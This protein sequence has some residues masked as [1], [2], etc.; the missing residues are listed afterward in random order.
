[1]KLAC[2]Y[3]NETE[4]LARESKIDIDYFKFPALGF[5]MDVLQEQN[6]NLFRDFISRVTPLKPVL[7]HGLYP[8]RHDVSSETFIH[9]FDKEKV[10]LFLEASRTPGISLHPCLGKPDSAISEKQLINTIVKNIGFLQSAYPRMDFIAI[11]NPDAPWF[12]PLL[13]PALLSEI[14]KQAGCSFLL[15]ISHAFCGAYYTGEDFKEY[16]YKLPLAQVSEVHINGWVQKGEDLIM[17]HTKINEAGYKILEEL[18]NRCAPKIITIEYGRHND[19]IGAGCPVVAP[20]SMNKNAMDEIV[21]QVERMK[22]I[23][24]GAGR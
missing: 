19:R 17:C 10:N 14:V 23:I 16:L 24:N 21:E 7:M 8:G 2:N 15:D 20:D 4:R 5:Q 22:E 1:M 18:L 13:K 3:L 12:G 6:L 9:D 11:E